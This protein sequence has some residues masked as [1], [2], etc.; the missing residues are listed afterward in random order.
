VKQLCT[1]NAL[2]LAI[3]ALLQPSLWAD[4]VTVRQLEGELHGFLVLRGLDDAI[5]ADGDLIQTT[6]GGEVSSRLVYRF[7][8][9]SLQDETAVLSQRGHFRLLTD[10][11]VQKGPTF[12]HPMDVSINGATGMVTVHYSDD[13]GKSKVET[14]SMALPPDLANGIV[15][16]LLKNLVS[17]GQPA[18]FSMVVAAPKPMLV[19]LVVTPEGG[20]SFTTEGAS[21]QA[22]RYDIKVDIGGIKGVVAPL[23][24]KQ[25]PDTHVWI[26]GGDSPAFVRSEGPLF[27]SGPILRTELVSPA[28]PKGGAV[29]AERKK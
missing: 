1:K 9:G 14:K 29:T 16:I 25:P 10:R 6:R 11:L 15:P 3:A 28:W 22:T 20:D 13:D 21:H 24:G 27:E 5:I 8:D 23:F 17:S 2:V 7:K 4:P 19:K 26:L 18:T 12:K